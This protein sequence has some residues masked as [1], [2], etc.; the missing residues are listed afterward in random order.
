MR[1]DE[2]ILTSMLDDDLYKLTTG[3][4]VFHNF[5]RAQVTYQ[6]FNRG[7]TKFPVGFDEELTRQIKLMQFLKLSEKE[8]DW[9]YNNLQ[10]F[11]PTFI[12][13]FYSYRLN[14]EEVSVHQFEG[15]LSI[16]IQ[17]NWFR[18]IY[19]EV[20]LMS[21]ISE[22]YFR[23]TKQP[24][25][26]DWEKRIV[27]KAKKFEDTESQYIE[28]G[29]RRRFSFITQDRAVDVM[30]DNNTFLGTSNP[31]LAFKY[32]V[33][34]KGT[35]PH[36]AIMACSVESGVRHADSAWRRYWQDFFQDASLSIALT[37]TFTTPSFLK[38]FLPHEAATWKGLRQD[39]GDPNI[40]ADKYVL[41]F[42]RNLG[43]DTQTKT[44]IFSDKLD[45]KKYIALSKKYRKV[46]NIIGGIGTHIT[47]DVG[48]TPLNM[49]IKMTSANFGQGFKP[50]V[51]LSDDIGKNTGQVKT[52]LD[53][54]A[55]LG[56]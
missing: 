27:K 19:W 17:G 18:A 26:P 22:L 23:L 21:V 29:T 30:K 52:I 2:P 47:N 39:S 41:P 51:K 14:P 8:R 13:W 55:A 12:E 42:Y 33:S 25:A 34:V 46:A 24:M 1:V 38:T 32:G 45:T 11:P 7:R 3:A 48:V 31:Y 43:I 44:L 9:M 6:F 35:Y 15:D 16:Q 37:D 5:P 36:E 10:F 28:F 50:V 56:I 40:W 49:V 53:V 4:V 54:K 20:K